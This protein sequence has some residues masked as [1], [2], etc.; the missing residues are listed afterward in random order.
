MTTYRENINQQYGREKLGD[1]I[2]S[3]LAAAGIDTDNLTR[4]DLGAFD[5]FH[6]GGRAETRKLASRVPNLGPGMRVLD[7]GSGI[8][9]PAR[10]LADEF[11]CEVVGLDLTE[12]YCKAA[13]T[14]TQ[15]IGL[16]DKVTFQHGDA[17]DMPF[18][19]DR[20]DVVWTQFAGMNIQD[21][22]RFYAECNRVLRKDGFFAFHEVMD[23]PTPDL[24]FP[25]FWANSDDVNFLHPPESI[26]QALAESGFQ[27][28]EWVDLTE[29]STDWFENMLVKTSNQPPKVGFN[30]FVGE[31]TPQKAANIIENLRDGR[32]IVV[33]AIYRK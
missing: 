4:A 10:T 32:I 9:G 17:L 29:H 15:R 19:D 30:V 2:L 6:I 11:G 26:Q 20:F 12:A 23:G 31:D 28:H 3:A 27:Q 14:L 21:K 24:I 18:E 8:G 25:V 33:Q 22:A 7:V 13:K 5:E 16:S 1:Q